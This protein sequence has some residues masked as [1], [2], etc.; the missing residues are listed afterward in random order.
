MKIKKEQ[1]TY[2]IV[3]ALL[4][5]M[6]AIPLYTVYKVEQMKS[7]RVNLKPK[8]PLYDFTGEFQQEIKRCV[9]QYDSANS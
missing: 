8:V 6:I 5:A 4:L 2:C 9:Y 1:Y 7:S 3:V